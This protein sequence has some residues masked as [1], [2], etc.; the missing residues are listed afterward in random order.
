MRL[1]RFREETKTKLCSQAK[2]AICT[3]V[4]RKQGHCGWFTELKLKTVFLT[5]TWALLVDLS[6][7]GHFRV[8]SKSNNVYGTLVVRSCHYSVLRTKLKQNFVRKR[9]TLQPQ[10]KTIAGSSTLLDFDFA[11]K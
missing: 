5:P 3:Q 9:K 10:I 6:D 2:F 8:K 7:F 11:R 1:Q 4:F